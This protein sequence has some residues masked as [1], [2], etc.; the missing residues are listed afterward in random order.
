MNQII[1][2]KDETDEDDDDEDPSRNQMGVLSTKFTSQ[3]N[4]RI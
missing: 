2:E 4:S 1:E 3:M